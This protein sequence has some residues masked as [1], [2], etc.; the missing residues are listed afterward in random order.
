MLLLKSQKIKSI[1]E[2]IKN[3]NKQTIDNIKK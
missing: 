3:L 1:R 2:E